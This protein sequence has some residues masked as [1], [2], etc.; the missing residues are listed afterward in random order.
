MGCRAKTTLKMAARLFHFL[1]DNLIPLVPWVK[2]R[3][4]RAG[5]LLPMAP[6]NF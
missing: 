1:L 6:Q 4:G 2:G 3:I 5:G